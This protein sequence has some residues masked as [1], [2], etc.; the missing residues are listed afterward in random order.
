MNPWTRSRPGTK[1]IMLQK[2]QVLFFLYWHRNSTIQSEVV[3]V[4]I[5]PR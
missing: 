5:E 1:K 4:A 3:E 2:T